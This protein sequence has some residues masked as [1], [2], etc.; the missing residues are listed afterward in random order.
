MCKGCAACVGLAIEVDCF[1]ALD[2]DGGG[3]AEPDSDAGDEA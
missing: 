1:V 2:A 3:A